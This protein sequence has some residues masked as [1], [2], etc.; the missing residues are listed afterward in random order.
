M[1]LA[2]RHAGI[3]YDPTNLALPGA[4]PAGGL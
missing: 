1:N 4:G 3:A 2:N